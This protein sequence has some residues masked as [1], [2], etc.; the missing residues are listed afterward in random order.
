M[1]KINDAYGM[2]DLEWQDFDPADWR[3]EPEPEDS[4]LDD[5]EDEPASP[6]VISMLGFDP[7]DLDWDEGPTDN[8]NVEGCN[9]YTGPDCGGTSGSEGASV[10]KSEA[11]DAI[12]KL[13]DGWGTGKAINPFF[14]RLEQDSEAGLAA[15]EMPFVLD[16]DKLQ[17]E[18]ELI[19]LSDIAGSSQ[20][21]VYRDTVVK[22]LEQSGT[23]ILLG[24][25]RGKLI[26]LDGNH[27]AVAAL[28]SGAKRILA[29]VVTAKP[30]HATANASTFDKP[31]ARN[32]C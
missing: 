19:E 1:S 3:D 28:L 12:Q 31:K 5:D 22:K 30:I 9:Q 21:H 16:A 25:S 11:I 27:T 18:P 4:D 23:P 7:D 20:R 2:A 15:Y 29:K 10:S 17:I 14:E 24:R 13:P 8:V 6:D 32:E 26:I